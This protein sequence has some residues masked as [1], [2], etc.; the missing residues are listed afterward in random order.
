MKGRPGNCQTDPSE[1]MKLRLVNGGSR[2]AGRLEIHYK[3]DWGTVNSYDW[4]LPDAAVVC[5]QLDC[6]AAL[7]API[8]AHFGKGSGPVVT[9]N[10][11][12]HGSEAV[13]QECESYPWDHY[14]TS[15]DYDAG[16]ICAGSRSR[17][18]GGKNRCSGRVE[19]LHRD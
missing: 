15:H 6:G 9:W 2:C 5:R 13:L 19:V 17:L 18:V 10:V 4:D 14:C 11:H 3:G 8:G 12:C 1:S 7:K 16:V